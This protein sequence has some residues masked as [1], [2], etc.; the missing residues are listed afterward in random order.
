MTAVC[1]IWC[2][3][4]SLSS[5]CREK[6]SM[7]NT[8][9]DS[10]QLLALVP[11]RDVRISLRAWSTSLFS[12]GLCGAWSFPWVMP[13]AVLKRPL[14]GVKLKNC[15]LMLRR[16][17]GLSGGKFMTGPPTIAALSDN[18]IFGPSVDIGLSDIFYSFE[19]VVIRRVSPLV[20]GAALCQAG[21][22]PDANPPSL[23]FRAAALANMRF[24]PLPSERGEKNDFSFEWEIGKLYWL[25]KH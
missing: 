8:C 10:L 21:S 11:H 14:S 12:G 4:F 3:G 2:E 13:I 24:R 18:F 6:G 16:A 7:K 5:G 1:R 22:L 17:I 19:D 20:I 15:A 25:P 23:S 9:S